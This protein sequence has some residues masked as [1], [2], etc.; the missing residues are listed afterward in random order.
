MA[1]TYAELRK[2]SEADL[3]RLYDETATS[4]QIGLSFLREE[5]ARREA[6]RQYKHMLRLTKQ[7]R[8]LTIVI[9][10]LTVVNLGAVVIAML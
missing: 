10:V 2:Q 6:E 7:M 9:T 1:N 3:E 5:L 8:D 4:T